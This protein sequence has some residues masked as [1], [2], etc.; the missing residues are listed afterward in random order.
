[1]IVHFVL[2]LSFTTGLQREIQ[3][4]GS[5]LGG[6]AGSQEEYEATRY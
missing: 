2:L 1:M 6:V 3:T 5:E 4:S